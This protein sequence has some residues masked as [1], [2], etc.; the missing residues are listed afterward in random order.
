MIDLAHLMT[1]RVTLAP[2]RD[3]G[4]TPV[5]H[6]RII[7]IAGGTFEGERL[8]GVILPGGADWQFVRNDGAVWLDARYTLET[9]DGALIYVR[10]FGIRHGPADA[11][12]RLG[13]GEP[14]DPA[15]IYCR[16]T[17]QFETSSV[18][19]AWLNRI[20]SVATATRRPDSIEIDAYEVT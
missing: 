19:H 8:N 20:V 11:L 9:D 18:R 14:V 15:L 13:R 7:D 10:N 2:I 1:L 12:A 5:G 6:R 4:E 16:T 3:L 17:P